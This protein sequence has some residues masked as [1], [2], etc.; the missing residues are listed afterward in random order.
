[1]FYWSLTAIF[2][3]WYH[4]RADIAITL[5]QALGASHGAA[6]A[7]GA[8]AT[9]AAS[10]F[11]A[12]YWPVTS[13]AYQSCADVLTAILPALGAAKQLLTYQSVAGA[14]TALLPVLAAVQESLAVLLSTAGGA[15]VAQSTSL[16]VGRVVESPVVWAAASR[17]P[18]LLLWCLGAGVCLGLGL[19]AAAGVVCCFLGA[20]QGAICI[21]Y[22]W[23]CV[24]SAWEMP[25]ARLE[26]WA[27]D[28]LYAIGGWEVWCRSTPVGRLVLPVQGGWL[29]RAASACVHCVARVGKGLLQAG[30]FVC[31]W[32]YRFGMWLEDELQLAGSSR[33]TDLRMQ[34]RF[35][36]ALTSACCAFLALCCGVAGAGTAVGC[37]MG[38]TPACAK[39]VPVLMWVP[40]FA[41]PVMV[42]QC[43]W[44]ATLFAAE[45]V[46]Q[47]GSSWCVGAWWAGSA[48]AV[49][50]WGWTRA[51]GVVAG[52]VAWRC[53]CWGAGA[54]AWALGA[55]SRKVVRKQQRH[56]AAVGVSEPT[57]TAGAQQA[58]VQPGAG[59]GTAS[60]QHEAGLQAALQA[61]DSR[62]V[63]TLHTAVEAAS[64]VQAAVVQPVL[65]SGVTDEQ[66][67]TVHMDLRC[68]RSKKR[69]T[70]ADQQRSTALSVAPA[71][72]LFGGAGTTGAATPA[73]H[74]TTSLWSGQQYLCSQPFGRTGVPRGGSHPAYGSSSSSSSSQPRQL[75]YVSV[76]TPAQYH[77][78]GS[79]LVPV[80][81]ALPQGS[82]LATQPAAGGGA[83]VVAA[84]SL[85]PPA[86]HLAMWCSSS[87][88]TDMDW[89]P[90]Q[91]STAPLQAVAAAGDMAAA[92]KKV[93][94]SGSASKQQLVTMTTADKGKGPM[95]SSSSASCDGPMAMEW[96]PAQQSAA[97]R[98]LAVVGSK[99]SAA[100]KGTTTSSSSKQL[101]MMSAADKG[102]GPMFSS[103]SKGKG[104]MAAGSSSFPGAKVSPVG[105]TAVTAGASPSKPAAAGAGNSMS[106]IMVPKV[107]AVKSSMLGT[108]NKGS[109]LGSGTAKPPPRLVLPGLNGSSNSSSSRAGPY[110]SPVGVTA[111]TTGAGPSK[112][113]AAASSA[114]L[115]IIVPKAG[116]VKSSLMGGAKKPGFVGSGA[117][118]PKAPAAPAAS[119]VVAVPAPPPLATMASAAA[120][121]SSTLPALVPA[122]PAVQMAAPAVPQAAAGG[123]PVL[124]QEPDF[125]TSMLPTLDE[126]AEALFQGFA[127]TQDELQLWERNETPGD[128]S[129]DE[130]PPEWVAKILASMP[131]ELDDF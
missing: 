25:V 62:Q 43:F 121:A 6:L 35:C 18:H 38:D 51:C 81:V 23:G 119:A 103:S 109:C 131:D 48:A 16:A 5:H 57:S 68:S 49:V 93:T 108:G 56:V 7:L 79:L 74:A 84:S 130:D 53:M 107:V 82:S 98:A 44:S 32:P 15:T 37:V 20:L 122:A 101:G 27:S 111:V 96:S 60:S 88:P 77:P 112:P 40:V 94:S 45:K 54:A 120:A 105:V 99:P 21:A 63:A 34:C 95:V 106:S 123:S 71:S 28:C 128:A 127:P 17:V 117:A 36:L 92:A 52:S 39:V 73:Q 11:G 75:G 97:P 86:S 118:K 42:V 26:A 61:A 50:V 100:K 70:F 2:L 116:A 12:W 19:V 1:V 102:K 83:V 46:M 125:L 13:S 10:A 29:H 65:R 85:T 4:C 78:A 64:G 58:V 24:S 72:S 126:S 129:D 91:Q 8:H 67:V 22:Q 76:H 14:F 59:Q 31:S 80:P 104:P 41:L 89:S 9:S 69:V 66:A 55:F 47:H 3:M 115:S 30:V 114:K 33:C 90:V 110:V 113:A 124:Q 87:G